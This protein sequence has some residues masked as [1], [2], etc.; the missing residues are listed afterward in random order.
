MPQSDI[1]KAFKDVLTSLYPKYCAADLD[2]VQ[3][4]AM[5]ALTQ[6]ILKDNPDDIA[7]NAWRGDYYCLHQQYGEALP[8]LEKA[9]LKGQRDN[10]T[11]YNYAQSLFH[12][13]AYDCALFLIEPLVEKYSKDFHLK[14]MEAYA[15]FRVGNTDQADHCFAQCIPYLADLQHS[16]GDQIQDMLA[17][18][19]SRGPDLTP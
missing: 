12:E 17:D 6:S 3:L 14:F 10:H 1:T 8:H 2:N 5:D 11:L 18:K 19:Y 13:E 4:R 15:H 16:Y 7:I 9:Y